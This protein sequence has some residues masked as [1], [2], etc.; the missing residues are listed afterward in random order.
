MSCLVSPLTCLCTC[1]ASSLVLSR[2]SF[3]VSLCLC[4][5][6]N[7][8]VLCGVC[9]VPVCTFKNASVCPSKTP[10]C[11]DSKRP[12][13]YR[14]HA[15]MCYHMRAWCRYTRG[16]FEST[17]GGF[18]DGQTGERGGKEGEG[19]GVTVSSAN[20]ETAHVELSRASERFTERNPWF[21]PIQGLR[22]S[23][24]QH[25]PESSNHSLYLIRLFSFSNLDRKL[26][27]ESA[28]TTHTITNTKTPHNT[29]TQHTHTHQP[30]H[31]PTHG[32]TD[33]PNTT[34]LS[35]SPPTRTRTRTCTC[36]CTYKEK[37]CLYVI[38]NRHGRNN[39]RNGIAWAQT[40]HGTFT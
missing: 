26:R 10:P 19:S 20:H 8:S 5:C 37:C 2:L 24:E 21:L 13:V 30:T 28:H 15:R 39:I 7:L 18:W 29:H 9:G 3:S 32:P 35:S 31:P 23:R 27:R 16:R 22:T 12:R 11:V 6:V 36:T 40:S 33:P 17:H 25:V 1:L 14:H 4:L 34:H 38:M